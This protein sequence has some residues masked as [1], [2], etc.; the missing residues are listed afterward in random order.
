MSNILVTGAAGFIGSHLTER[1]LADG[2]TVVGLDCFI[3]TYDPAIK[4]RNIAEALAHEAFTLVEGDIRDADIVDKLFA[5]HRLDAVIHLAALAGVRPSIS[6]AALFSD[7]NLTGT[8]RLLDAAV[9]HGKPRFVF[10]SS[11]SVYGNNKKVP[12]SETDA[13]DFP[14]SPYAATKRSGELLCHTYH[15][16][17]GLDI[18]CLRFFTVYG[19]RQRP[20]LAIGKFMR[21]ISAGEAIPVFGDGTT[22]RDYTFVHD[23]VDGVIAAT[24]RCSGYDIFNLGSKRPITLSELIEAIGKTVGKEAI[25]DRQPMQPGDVDRTFADVSHSHEKLGYAPRVTL[26]EGLRAQWEW[27]KSTL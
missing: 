13:V 3:D 27:L 21:L 4:R 9:K 20:D 8:V 17:H 7:I 22:S 6:Q 2:H 18:A 24:E 12:F 19:P 16:V 14:I 1:L 10:G 25:I 23:I 15:H 5:E 26:E 11:S